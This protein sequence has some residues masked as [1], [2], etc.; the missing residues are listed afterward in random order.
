MSIQSLPSLASTLSL[1]LTATA[2]ASF[3]TP[4]ISVPFPSAYA[5]TQIPFSF[6]NGPTVTGISIASQVQVGGVPATAGI[7]AIPQPTG[8]ITYGQSGD[9]ATSPRG[10]LP[11]WAIGTIAAAGG[12]ALLLFIL[13]VYC[14]STRKTAKR[15]RRAKRSRM[16]GNDYSEKLGSAGEVNNVDGLRRT[17]SKRAPGG[18]K[19]R[20]TYFGVS[21][22]APTLERPRKVARERGGEAVREQGKEEGRYALGVLPSGGE[23][24]DS[25]QRYST[26]ST[27]SPH[28][29]N[30]PPTTPRGGVTRADQILFPSALP[31]DSSSAQL[32]SLQSL[33]HNRSLSSDIEQPRYARDSSDMGSPARLL[34]RNQDDSPSSLMGRRGNGDLSLEGGGNFEGIGRD[35][36]RTRSYTPDSPTFNLDEMPIGYKTTTTSTSTTDRRRSLPCVG[37]GGGGDAQVMRNTELNSSSSWVSPTFERI[38]LDSPQPPV[39]ASVSPRKKGG[40]GGVEREIDY[41]NQSGR[42]L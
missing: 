27:L 19:V 39:P 21:G 12:I 7:S 23:G 26:D 37:M 33:G 6:I 4:A 28:P 2:F 20:S 5:Q 11:H 41:E 17:T 10:G 22:V 8:G 16:I 35:R 31:Y 30:G 1:S 18:N 29:S 9:S 13:G 15:A 42:A 24:Y 38:E 32:I 3:T 34:R 14:W 40:Q 25:L 36:R